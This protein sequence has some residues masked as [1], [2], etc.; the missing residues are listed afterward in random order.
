MPEQVCPPML[1][2]NSSIVVFQMCL[3]L[4]SVLDFV[5][6][7]SKCKVVFILFAHVLKYIHT[8]YASRF[9]LS[10]LT[11][12]LETLVTS[13]QPANGQSVQVDTANLAFSVVCLADVLAQGVRAES[14]GLGIGPVSNL[15]SVTG[16]ERNIINGYIGR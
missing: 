4:T 10:R 5:H 6:I 16:E 14:S 3:T 13:I 11:S 9:T 1:L 8:E 12:S 15:T 2:G 7:K